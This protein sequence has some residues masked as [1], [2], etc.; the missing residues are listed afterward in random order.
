MER[1]LLEQEFG[2]ELTLADLDDAA[3]AAQSAPVTGAREHFLAEV[4]ARAHPP[5]TVGF[6]AET[7]KLEK[8]ARD[9]LERKSLDMIAANPVGAPGV[10]FGGDVNRLRVFWRHGERDLGEASKSEL[11]ERLVALVAERFREKHPA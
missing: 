5:F 2:F 11:A 10:G 3:D 4:A 1:I 8:H 6:A 7:E 9:K